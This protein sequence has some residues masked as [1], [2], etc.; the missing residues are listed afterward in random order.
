MSLLMGD[1][2][3]ED[4]PMVERREESGLLS[5]GS[6][7]AKKGGPAVIPPPKK[8]MASQG[9]HLHV[10]RGFQK[11]A[12][13]EASSAAGLFA[14]AADYYASA[15][16]ALLEA[17]TDQPDLAADLMPKVKEFMSAEEAARE[18]MRAAEVEGGGD[19]LS[20]GDDAGAHSLPEGCRSVST[21]A[22]EISWDRRFALSGVQRA[23][24][25]EEGFVTVAGAVG[26]ALVASALRDVNT[27]LFRA[28]R[29][30]V[31]L[32]TGGTEGAPAAP[33]KGGM[34][35]FNDGTAGQ[36]I[37]F[38]TTPALMDLLFCSGAWT[39]A[40][41]LLGRSKV[42]RP[43]DVQVAVRPP[44]PALLL[45]DPPR[46]LFRNGVVDDGK[47]WHLDGMTK[48]GQH[49]P[50]SVLLGVALSDQNAGNLCGNLVVFPGS[51]LSLQ[52]L[53]AEKLKNGACSKEGFFPAG[54][55]PWPSKPDLGSGCAL[56][57]AAGDVVICHQKLAHRGGAN[58]S[59]HMRYM[60]FFRLSHVRHDDFASSGATVNDIWCEFE[61]LNSPCVDETRSSAEG[62]GSG[63]SQ[64]PL[65]L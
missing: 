63:S 55:M 21:V 12:S 49:S 24:F 17:I 31:D 25:R 47:R 44:E 38:S 14:D 42:A 46:A 15:A 35:A 3:D 45:K 22:Q 39:L 65:L 60:A 7:A 56:Q 19:L 33:E 59:A 8:L 64:S 26:P 37:Q 51:H 5:K 16:A 58:G 36:S 27:A 10:T 11:G 30:G 52:P 40:Q 54:E 20:G 2:S 29:V 53:L 4:A 6:P 1:D 50:F 34:V 9:A 62:K 18:T 13:G 32:L 43:R 41:Q 23:R 28:A 61:G 48:P 57:M